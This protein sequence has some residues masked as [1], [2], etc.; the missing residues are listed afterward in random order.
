MLVVTVE[1]WPGGSSRLR[2]PIGTMH[3]GNQSDL[4]DVSDYW[5]IAMATAN[6]LTGE[7]AGIA[8]FPV[9]AHPRRQRVW[10]LIQRACEEAGM[11]DWTD[12]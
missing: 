5:V 3:I 11:A 9:L 7:P 1:L 8:Q 6:P 2:R 10:A 12:L 4:A